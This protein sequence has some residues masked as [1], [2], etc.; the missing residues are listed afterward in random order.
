MNNTQLDMVLGYLNEGTEINQ[1][2][3]MMESLNEMVEQSIYESAMIDSLL[4]AYDNDI[5]DA[6]FRELNDDNTYKDG[7]SSK[8]KD[9]RYKNKRNIIDKIGDA[10]GRFITWVGEL[11]TKLKAQIA[12]LKIKVLVPFIKKA[13]EKQKAK[14]K[15]DDPG[16]II[17]LSDF[18]TWILFEDELTT[19]QSMLD[20]RA[21]FNKI[22]SENIKELIAN[23]PIFIILL[24]P[25]LVKN[26]NTKVS[27]THSK[28][29]TVGEYLQ[30]IDKL[31]DKAKKCVNIIDDVL[32]DY[33]SAIA[34][35]K[36]LRKEDPD[37]ASK[38][39]REDSAAVRNFTYIATGAVKATM[40]MLKLVNKTIR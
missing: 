36:K 3:F 25:A 35:A 24:S 26:Y 8:K 19:K 1:Y 22:E 39:L 27:T 32:K 13:V 16:K 10:I 29:I 2:D 6:E 40:I 18:E 20:F 31:A 21:S 11:I 38:K 9:E 14:L 33:N 17:E 15:N 30:K 4:E 12:K 34:E 23:V 28:E 37:K 5:E 7:N